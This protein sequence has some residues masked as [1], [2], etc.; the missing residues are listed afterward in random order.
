MN[1]YAKQRKVIS[2][3]KLHRIYNTNLDSTGVAMVYKNHDQ[4]WQSSLMAVR[5]GD[6]VYA[7]FPTTK[8]AGS[9][10]SVYCVKYNVTDSPLDNIVFKPFPK[11]IQ[12]N[13]EF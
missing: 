8:Q 6:F 4:G 2:E 5:Y 3:H 12:N 13:V 11:T 10:L 1:R 9:K 7:V